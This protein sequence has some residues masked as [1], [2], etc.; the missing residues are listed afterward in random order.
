[1]I[2]EGLNEIV[3]PEL[4]AGAIENT[5]YV[6]FREDYLVLH[7]LIKTYKPKTFLEVGTHEGRG[8]EIICN[9]GKDFGMRVYSLDLPPE[10]AHLTEQYPSGPGKVPVG[11]KCKLPFAQLWGDSL[12][13]DFGSLY[14][15]GWFIDGEHDHVHAYHEA[16][17]AIKS[18]AK[19]I[20]FHDADIPA[21]ATGICDA[22]DE[23]VDYSLH[24]VSKTRIAYLVR[25]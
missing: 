20:V 4:S 24:R 9:A 22:Y 18:G 3:T 7:C 17:E 11:S 1:M 14:L 5:D 25:L 2:F 19:L 16:Q 13:F 21:V 8:T 6:G 23:T 10:L 12:G 15:D